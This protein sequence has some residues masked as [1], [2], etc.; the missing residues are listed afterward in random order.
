MA[1]SAR[2]G[3]PLSPEEIHAEALR[4]IDERG[5]EALSM[6]KLA[7]ALDVNPMSLYHHVPNKEALLDGVR[8]LVLSEIEL[9]ADDS[10]DWREQIRALGAGLRALA[11]RHPSLYPYMCA[12]PGLMHQDGVAEVLRRVL[13]AAGVPAER[14]GAM[15]NALFAFTAGFLLSEINGVFPAPDDAAFEEALT[16]IVNGLSAYGR[17]GSGGT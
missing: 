9:P 13:T 5:V 3:T 15:R 14:L 6:R 12:H 2:R 10:S 8:G 7:A 4:L 1:V 16:L 11:H 17:D